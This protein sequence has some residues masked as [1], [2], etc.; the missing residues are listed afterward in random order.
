MSENLFKK[1]GEDYKKSAFSFCDDYKSFL[2]EAKTE[3]RCAEYFRKEAEKNGFK[4]LSDVKNPKAGDKVYY[5]NRGRSA[6]FAVLGE[7]D[8]ENGMNLVAAHIDSPRLDLK[9]SPV[10]Q[11]G[12]LAYFRTHYYGGIKKYQWVTIPL[13]A[14]GVIVKTNGE[15][16]E[17][18]IGDNEGDP[19]FTVTDLLPHLATKQVLKKMTEGITGE[20]LMVLAGSDES[21][22]EKDPVKDNLL[23]L[24]KDA[25]GI[26]EEDF[27]SAEIQLV[28][29]GKASDVGFDR[30]MVGGYGHDDRVCA[31]TAFKGIMNT[32]KPKKTAVVLLA[33]REEVGSMGNSGM[34]SKFLHYFIEE[35]FGIVKMNT[36]FKNTRC[37]SSDV[38]ATYDPIYPEVYDLQNSPKAGEGIAL[39]RYTGSR[40]KGGSSEASAEFT[41]E[42]RGLLDKN[43]VS[44]QFAELGK[45]DEGGGGTV[46][47][48]IANLGAEVIDAGVALLCMHSPFEVAHKADIYEAFRAYEAFLK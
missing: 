46:A 44:Y 30:S 3:R 1:N 33:D 37:L 31:Y 24:L 15:K 11:E 22:A 40:G 45:V 12:N 38:A 2:T 28:P 43:N 23:K 5:I 17:V 14:Y 36:V 8:I 32:E 4:P 29:A 7:E 16:V 20:K 27:R 26:C 34:Q 39:L 6:V 13:A 9:P 18:N 35:L 10:T 42:I 21:D 25:Y 47:Q 48:Y 41:A 19:V